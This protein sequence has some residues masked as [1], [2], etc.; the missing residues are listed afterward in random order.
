MVETSVLIKDGMT[1]VMGGLKKENKSH[2]Q[3][4]V[5]VL[6]DI[7]FVKKIFSSTS[8]SI[9]MT[10]IVIFITPHIITGDDDYNKYLGDLKPDNDYV[11]AEGELPGHPNGSLKLKE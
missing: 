8:E 9:E 5:P 10:E 1:V 11:R 6:M 7:P 2:V 3:K 4:G